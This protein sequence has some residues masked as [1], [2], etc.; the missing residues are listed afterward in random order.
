MSAMSIP[1]LL[2]LSL[3]IETPSVIFR[4]LCRIHA[5]GELMAAFSASCFTA[6]LVNLA[7]FSVTSRFGALSMQVFGNMKTVF[8]SVT[9]VALFQNVV[10]VQG[11]LGYAM[12]ILGVALF[13][14]VRR[15]MF[16]F[17]VSSV[18]QCSKSCLD[19]F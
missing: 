4:K 14:L 16:D 1:S 11:A 15:K 7:Q 12:T 10:T 5:S 13:E 9:S 8:V 3:T 17:N 2:I 19:G 6:F 18:L